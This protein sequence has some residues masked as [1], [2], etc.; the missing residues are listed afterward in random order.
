MLDD[1]AVYTRDAAGAFTQKARF[2]AAGW[3]MADLNGLVLTTP[4]HE[5]WNYALQPDDG[6]NGSWTLDLAFKRSPPPIRR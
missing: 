4:G 2:D 3:H 6:N 5:P 1:T